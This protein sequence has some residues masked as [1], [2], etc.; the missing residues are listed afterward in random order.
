MQCYEEAA[1]SHRAGTDFYLHF[2]FSMLLRFLLANG[3]EGSCSADKASHKHTSHKQ[4]KT[5]S[6]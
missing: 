4:L 2:P 6:S 5:L 3:H 1:E